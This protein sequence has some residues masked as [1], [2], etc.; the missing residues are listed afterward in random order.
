MCLINRT[1]IFN[2]LLG[3]AGRNLHIGASNVFNSNVNVTRDSARVVVMDNIGIFPSVEEQIDFVDQTGYIFGPSMLATINHIP[4]VLHWWKEESRFI[5]G[6]SMH[7]IVTTLS[8]DLIPSLVKHKKQI[9]QEKKMKI[10]ILATST[11]KEEIDRP[12]WPEENNPN[13]AP[14]AEE[15]QPAAPPLDLPLARGF[16]MLPQQEARPDPPV[17]PVPPPIELPLWITPPHEMIDLSGFE[18]NEIP[19]PPMPELQ[20]DGPETEREQRAPSAERNQEQRQEVDIVVS[21]NPSFSPDSHSS[22]CEEDADF[23]RRNYPQ[24]QTMTEETANNQSNATTSNEETLTPALV[25]AELPEAP[26]TQPAGETTF[27]TANNPTEGHLAATAAVAAAA[28]IAARID[29]EDEVPDGVDPSFLEALPPE[30]RREVLEQH[31]MLRL[32]ERISAT[33]VPAEPTASGSSE[34][35]PE[36]LAALPPSLQEEV[37]TQQRLEQQRQAATRANPDEP[38]DAA[39]FFETL[40]PSLRTMI[41]SDMEDSQMSALPPDLAAEAQTLRRDW[42]ARNRQMQVQERFLE[43]NLTT[44][45]R[46]TGRGRI[47]SRFNAAHLLPQWAQRPDFPSNHPAGS[48]KIRGRQL[49]DHEALSCLLVLLFV[50]DPKL[51]T[52]RLHRVIRNLCHHVPTRDWVV[53]ALLSIIDRSVHV[54]PDELTSNKAKKTPKPGPLSSKLT[55][56]SK[57]MGNGANWLNIRMEAALG[58]H[59]NV[60]IVNRAPGKRTEKNSSNSSVTIHSQA[61]PIVCRNALDI[62]TSLSRT[63]PTFLLPLKPKEKNKTE[64]STARNNKAE[65]TDFWDM[66]LKLDAA[67]TKKGKSLNKTHNSTFNLG[68]DTDNFVQSFE[69]SAFGA[70]LGMLSSN[71]IKGSIQLTDKLL[72]LLSVISTG[73][74]ELSKGDSSSTTKAIAQ[75]YESVAAPEAAL[76]LAVNVLTYKSC[77]E[78]GLEDVTALLLNLSTCS[79]EMSRSI[80][81]LLLQG[82]K[83]IG[84]IVQGQIGNMLTEL[85]RTHTKSNKPKEEQQGASTSKGILNNRFTN[86]HV[87]ITASSK[88][89]TS[90][91]LQLPSMAPLTSKS[92]SQVFFLRVLRVIVQIREAI[93]NKKGPDGVGLT[94]GPLS[95]QLDDPQGLW[96]T[97]SLCLLELEHTPDHHAVL[98]LQPAVEAF[99]LVHSPPQEAASTTENKPPANSATQGQ[100]AVQAPASQ[101]PAIGPPESTSAQG[102]AGEALVSLTLSDIMETSGRSG[103]QPEHQKFLTFAEMHR[104]VLNQILRQTTSHLA[105]GPFSVLVDHTRVLDFDIKRR[106]FRTEL[107]RLDQNIRREETA[108]HVRR[109]HVFEDSFRELYRRSPEEWKNRFYIVFEGKIIIF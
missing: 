32:Q 74:P 45:I 41:L 29:A 98:V 26:E 71:V 5:D 105:D 6:D 43:A 13:S 62:F 72:R 42:E 2:R 94:L 52:S 103:V 69:Q 75:N 12:F 38:V 56:D 16:G 86:E 80:L 66:L 44:I 93:T 39:S 101:T 3:P 51:N 15:Q 64:K 76:N 90:C 30:M 70:L 36:F 88:V 96:H 77:S 92:S 84:E 37:L 48:I 40:Q 47:A 10:N 61:A 21:E 78:E 100:A 7:D 104:T 102:E 79:L 65:S 53:R 14:P 82:A 68:A 9:A 107:D 60:F 50:D 109:E 83:R 57:N 27:S 95:E 99:F 18:Q 4:V 54:K 11:P 31:R 25:D 91:D 85:Q 46:H 97:L 8:N 55:T 106:Y 17:P 63:F 108:V 20:E 58:C 73:M 67:S 89:K 24:E 49:L 87:V 34:V 23:F 81:N 35:S 1:S 28:V 59:A 33:T 22:I 19:A